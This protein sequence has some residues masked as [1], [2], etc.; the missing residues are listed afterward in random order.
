VPSF[1]IG[2]TLVLH[3]LHINNIDQYIDPLE[4]PMRAS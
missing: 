2:C 4:I 1:F 3:E